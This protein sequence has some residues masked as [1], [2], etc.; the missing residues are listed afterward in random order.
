MNPMSLLPGSQQ[1]EC[2]DKAK[3]SLPDISRIT[4]FGIAEFDV[5][6]LIANTSGF[7]I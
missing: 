2:D 7:T 4:S 1:L 6:P 5:R 3:Q